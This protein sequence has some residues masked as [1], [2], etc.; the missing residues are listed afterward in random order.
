M[1]LRRFLI[2]MCTVFFLTSCARTC[3]KLERSTID[4]HEHQMRVSLYSGGQVV[5]TW[6][7]KGIINNSENSDGYFFY[8][9]NKLVEVSGDVVIE[10]LD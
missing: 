10:H 4:N 7:F 6:E 9:N 2:I 5:K 3:Q 1:K 8:Y